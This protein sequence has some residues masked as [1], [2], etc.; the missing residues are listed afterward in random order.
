MTFNLVRKEHDKALRK[1]YPQE[2]S[3]IQQVQ[4]VS[5]MAQTIR[6]LNLD[7]IDKDK[8]S[9]IDMKSRL[10]PE[11]ISAILCGDTLIS[12]GFLP[13]SVSYLTRSKKR[14]SVSELGK[15]REEVVAISQG[16]RDQSSS[17]TFGERFT[18][19]FR[20]GST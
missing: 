8:F 12:M 15:G 11:E 9:S 4:E 16:M 17:K 2:D 6:E 13:I 3:Q 1:E 14:L 7:S 5:D 20:G 10:H 18:N 19:L